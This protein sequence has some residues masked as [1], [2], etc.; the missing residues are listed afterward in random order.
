MANGDLT[1]DYVGRRGP[2]MRLAFVTSLLTVLT[3]GFYRFWMK[4]RLRRYYW[5]AIKPG[6]HPLEYVGEPLEKL[7]GFLVAVVFLAFYI[8][9]VNLILMYLSFSLF[10]GNFMAYV[11][12]FLG[13]VPV[14]FY[15]RY[16]ARRY[17]LTRTRWRGVRFGMDNGA[18]GYAWRAMVH[19]LITILSLGLL[20]PRKTFWLEKYRTDRT[21]FGES[22]FH[23]GGDW[24]ML[25]GPFLPIVIGVLII[26]I[27]GVV[28]W[29]SESGVGVL[30]AIPG[31]LL[32][33]YGVPHYAVHSFRRLTNS[34]SLDGVHLSVEPRPWRVIR[35]YLFGYVLVGL[36]LVIL[37]AVL[38]FTFGA[39]FY[40]ISGA[41][42]TEAFS[43]VE[44]AQLSL[45]MLIPIAIVYFSIFISWG[46][47]QK[48]FV[49][50]PLARHYAETLQIFGSE[51]LPE[52][53]QRERDEFADAEG[54]AEALDLGAA[55]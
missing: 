47:F 7:L 33:T 1:T 41:D 38:L 43:E 53:T 54:F 44:F 6:G 27:G 4:T 51:L 13:V 29:Q 9:I 40:A 37:S 12:S 34:K 11:L 8:G 36:A 18:W 2:L 3:L 50:L 52:I 30:I 24:K 32:L 22:R 19:W 45:G 39:I 31:V 15:A 25:Y 46:V 21:F 26:A 55:I 35:I 17:I 48:I 23:Q 14:M 49:T 42:P 16:R 28:E 10:A 5:S 20:W